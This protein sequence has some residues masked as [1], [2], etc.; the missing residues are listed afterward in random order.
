[1][2]RRL[3]PWIGLALVAAVSLAVAAGVRGDGDT[4]EEARVERITAD[5]RCP[6]CQGLSVADS[7]ST[8]AR[9]ITDDVRRRVAEGESDE[10]IRRAY[11]D[12]YGEWIL[13][14]PERGGIGLLVWAL[15]VLVLVAGGL[16]VLGVVVRG[17]RQPTL[18]ASPEDEALVESVRRE[19]ES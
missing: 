8:T 15:P 12:S 6:V 16:G 10:Q 19:R 17:R 5:L 3:A 18:S 13:L 7:N 1:M 4:S 2:L 14:E 11:V 9:A